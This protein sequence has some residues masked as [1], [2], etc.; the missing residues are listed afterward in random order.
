M[1]RRQY[2]KLVPFEA[3]QPRTAS[4]RFGVFP[5]NYQAFEAAADQRHSATEEL[6]RCEFKMLMKNLESQ[7]SAGFAKLKEQ[8]TELKTEIQRQETEIQRQETSRMDLESRT[9]ARIAK[10]TTENLHFKEK[11]QRM[12]ISLAWSSVILQRITF[13]MTLDK[14]GSMLSVSSRNTIQSIL[15]ENAYDGN[16][17]DPLL[18]SDIDYLLKNRGSLNS[19]AHKVD[20]EVLRAVPELFADSAM[21][22]RF[23]QFLE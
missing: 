8:N 9:D 12:E 18:P 15:N 19:S 21:T 10:L 5:E 2:F 20:I 7:T 1:A 17:I 14:I 22:Q 4:D 16:I 3:S 23:L 6:L 13:D 11:I